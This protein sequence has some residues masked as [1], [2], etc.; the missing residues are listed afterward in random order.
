MTKT[1]TQK[2]AGMQILMF[3]LPTKP[4]TWAGFVGKDKYFVNTPQ[5][6]PD[7]R[8]WEDRRVG[9]VSGIL[10]GATLSLWFLTLKSNT[11][12]F[13]C[14][15][16]KESLEFLRWLDWVNVRTDFHPECNILL[17]YTTVVGKCPEAIQFLV[18]FEPA[19][20]G[21]AQI[22]LACVGVQCLNRIAASQVSQERS[23]LPYTDTQDYCDHPVK[24]AVVLEFDI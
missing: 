16:Q 23:T 17:R 10:H 21:M 6:R 7:T 5:S 1:I 22:R 4:V 2:K 8:H 13:Y 9:H 20:F 3:I 12:F 14:L 15:R 19:T 18:G 24:F 11:L